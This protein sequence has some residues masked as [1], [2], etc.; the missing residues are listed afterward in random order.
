MITDKS[1]TWV[2]RLSIVD[3]VDSKTQILL[4]TLKTL[5]QLRGETCVSSEVEHYS[6]KLDVRNKL[7]FLTVQLNLKLFLSMLVCAWMVFTLLLFGVW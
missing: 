3:W 7:Q 2:T 6:F 5:N 1:V 4:E